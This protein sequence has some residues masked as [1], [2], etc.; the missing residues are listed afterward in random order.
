[1]NSVTV[2]LLA[3]KE[4]ENLRVLLPRIID[5]MTQIGADY[6]IL[7]VDTRQPMDDTP[8]VCA[9]FGARYVNQ[10]G[11]GFA[12][13]F[14]TA[15]DHATRELFLIMDSDGSHNP[16][17]IPEIYRKYTEDGCD[18]VI[19]SR[20]TE[21]GKTFDSKSS[22]V[23]SRILNTVF[24]LSLGIR[25]KDISTDFRLYDTHQLKAVTLENEN[26]DVLQE[27]LFK[28][29][30]NKPDLK[31]GEVPITFEKR[32][33]G[34]SKRRLIPFIISYVKSLFRLTAMRVREERVLL[35]GGV[36]RFVFCAAIFAMLFCWLTAVFVGGSGSDQTRLFYARLS[37]FQADF[38]NVVGYSAGLDP[39]H[40]TVYTGLGEKA[41]PPLTYLI[42]YAFS[43]L[44]NIETYNE[45][46]Y[47][48]DMY[49]EP[50]LLM[51]YMLYTI[52]VVVL[53]YE[54]FRHH[55]R[56]GRFGKAAVALALLFSRPMIASLERG[57]TI[58]LTLL[59]VTIFLLNYNDPRRGRR[60]WAC[61]SLAIAAA[62]KMMP[63]MLGILLLLDR[64]DWKLAIRT[65]IY[66]IIAFFLPFVFLK[67]NLFENIAQM[68][69]NIFENLSAYSWVHGCTFE[70]C[71]RS[72][73]IKG[74]SG[75]VA[76]V[77]YA[78]GAV[79]LAGCL[80]YPKQWMKLLAVAMVLV[81]LPSHSES[82]CVLYLFP[83]L[84][85]FLNEERHGA[86][87]WIILLAVLPV[88]RHIQS[89]ALDRV[90]GPGLGLLV[91]CAVMCVLAVASG[92]R[93]YKRP[94]AQA[95]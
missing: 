7:V 58:V 27:V 13:A 39:Y 45:N 8:Q 16:D 19:G 80:V 52:F 64:K 1:M 3:Y 76:I 6:E 68:F 75:L 40:N 67:G 31:I 42:T 28:L 41:Y 9:S 66:G 12:N 33:Y 46:N 30:L 37:D 22:I 47:F 32:L 81:V 83:A 57:N 4:A 88:M 93:R 50:L 69:R 29:R 72:V 95:R 92:I 11:K 53:L 90:M 63:A 26:Y 18:I 38:T 60:E 10:T 87:D 51:M 44:V 24:R 91:I 55:T 73:G 56:A 65:V 71:L 86:S 15:I 89:Q 43:R 2:A 35:K 94:S 48:L 36:F 34:E 78:V 54:V 62:L 23:M 20:Y 77:K 79:M 74:P 82:Y 5:K 70:S 49:Q 84:I 61:V 25:A 14:K 17:Y 21:G 85:A 59:F